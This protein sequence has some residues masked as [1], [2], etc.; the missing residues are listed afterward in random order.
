MFSC[1]IVLAAV[2]FLSPLEAK[3]LTPSIPTVDWSTFFSTVS[4]RG[5]EYAPELEALNGKR[6][7]LRGHAVI[8]PVPQGGL[9]LTRVPSERLH[10]DDEET[11]PWDSVIVLWRTGIML[12]P[13]PSRPTV[14]GTLRTG[15]RRIGSETVILTLEDAVPVVSPAGRRPSLTA[16]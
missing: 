16:N 8:E 6:V 13:I 11:L 3:S 5:A 9:F 4:V 10:P 1:S 7:R 2:L 12:P 15:N 14:E